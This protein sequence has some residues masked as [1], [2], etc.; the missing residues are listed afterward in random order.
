MSPG[1]LSAVI[2]AAGAGARL[3]EL[4]RRYSKPLVPVAG[5]PLIEWIIRSLRAAAVER[6]VVVGHVSDASLAAFL[7][8]AHPDITLVTQAERR[9]IADALRVALPRVARE[10]AYLACACDSL[11]E[12]EDLRRLVA[13]GERAPAEAV[14]GV[15]EMGTEATASRSAVCLDGD[16]VLEIVEKPAAGAAPSGFVAMPVY[17]LSRSASP[18][19]EADAPL[20][21]EAYITTALNAFIQAGGRVRAVR[22]SGRL[23]ITTAEDVA[24]AEAWLVRPGT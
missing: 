23:E 10:S 17:W 1:Q 2:L 16:H 7:R 14:I 19:I 18:Y 15:V 8:A 11:F 20:G 21:G 24:R 4:G 13:A 6:F 3:G 9:G 12:P 5:Q 22:M